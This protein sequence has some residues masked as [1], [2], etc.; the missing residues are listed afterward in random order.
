[1]SNLHLISQFGKE[2]FNVSHKFTNQLSRPQQGNFRELVRGMAITGSV[3]LST[4]A[5]S[6]STANNVRKDVERLSN[7]LNKI[8]ALSFTQLHINSQV[9][10]YKDEPVLILSDGGDFQKPYAKKM[11][12]VCGNVDGSNGHKTGK[13]YPLQ[14]L[15][16]Y[17]TESKMITPLAMH[18]F[19]THSEDY[20]G[21]WHEH[22]KTF[23]L[24][25][26]L[27]N[28]SSKDT[29]IVEDRGCDDEKRFMYFTNELGCSFV[30]RISAGN[31]SRGVVTIDEDKNERVHSIQELAKQ[32]KGKASDERVWY[33][34]K[35]KKEL[36]SKIAYQKV[37]LPKHKEVPLYAVF[38][39]S[40]GYD[41]PLVILT[42]LKTEN[43]IRAW[44]HFFYYKKR[45]EV[46]NFYRAIKQN[47]SAEKFLILGF[48]KIQALAFLLMLT[49]SLI[50]K[51]KNRI[52]EFL[53]SFMCFFIVFCKKGQRTG[54]HHLDVLTF[55]RGRIPLVAAEHSYRL[56]SRR[57]SKNRYKFNKDQFKLFDWRKKW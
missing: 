32:L 45:W 16:A 21:D 15:V 54:N 18:L 1:M 52:T 46:E 38:V 50:I 43:A 28:R 57:M 31:G 17:G 44:K 39:Y 10:N 24:L 8:P 22:R 3:H 4:V 56:W 6:N 7:T 19:S 29:V 33:N 35:T 14:S 25:A 9:S 36:T 26:P 48:K 20:K 49:F 53:G 42:D 12:K 51:I 37:F 13:G 47:F 55:L 5:K 23:N 27:V 30:T 40:E 41:E 11:E 34:K 2:V